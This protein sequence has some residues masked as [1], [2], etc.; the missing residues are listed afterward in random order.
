MLVVFYTVQMVYMCIFMICSTFCCLC[1]EL[2]DPW[3]VSVYICIY[4]CMYVY[5]TKS[6]FFHAD[7][8]CCSAGPNYVTHCPQR[9]VATSRQAQN[10]LR[11]TYS[12]FK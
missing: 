11:S 6:F 9:T 7:V 4:V 8:Q 3:N 1:D 10:Y 2:K 5:Q 12:T